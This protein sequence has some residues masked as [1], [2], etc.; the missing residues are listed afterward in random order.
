MVA[1]PLRFSLVRSNNFQSSDRAS[2]WHSKRLSTLMSWRCVVPL[3]CVTALCE[4][5]ASQEQGR[6]FV[7]RHAPVGIDSD[8][9]A[10]DAIACAEKRTR[11]F[12]LTP[13]ALW[14]NEH[15]CISEFNHTY[16]VHSI[17]CTDDNCRVTILCADSIESIKHACLLTLGTIALLF[18]FP[19][20]AQLASERRLKLA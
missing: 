11:I 18:A 14:C 15:D 8:G 20:L 7:H 16:D 13:N 10:G 12:A 9:E 17:E 2:E 6:Q 4:A 1:S 3:L 19:R 5:A